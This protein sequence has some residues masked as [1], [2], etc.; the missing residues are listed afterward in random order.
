M[1]DER[2]AATAIA[3]GEGGD[4]EALGGVDVAQVRARVKALIDSGDVTM[5]QIS[6]ECGRGCSTGVLSPF[7]AGKYSGDSTAAAEILHRWLDAREAKD[8]LVAV[9]PAAPKFVNTEAARQVLSVLRYAHMAGDIGIIY[10]GAGA[11]KTTTAK[12]Y[13]GT[14]NN[15]WHVQMTSANAGMLAALTRIARATA[16]V[17][18]RMWV[19]RPPWLLDRI[20]AK[21]TGTAGLLIVDEAQHLE[22][23]SIEAIRAINDH[24][25]V[26]VVL[27][28]NESLHSR[29][30]GGGS[31]SAEF[32]QLYSRIGKPL[33]LG[34]PSG[35]DVRSLAQAWG[36]TGGAELQLLGQIAQ[37]PGALRAVTKTI[38]LACITKAGR[39]L[40]ATDLERAWADL[41]GMQ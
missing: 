21:L 33:R 35:A 5:S 34:K 17:P 6:K 31:R 7:L 12:E 29:I 20:V 19:Q 10:G 39:A 18:E 24:T 25:E 36:I 40:T 41:G 15:V 22:V 16:A 27:M 8:Q 30:T 32:A 38:R 3:G 11:G 14:T 26:G 23:A 1:K 2:E 28:G 4:G 9:M 37:K 13:A